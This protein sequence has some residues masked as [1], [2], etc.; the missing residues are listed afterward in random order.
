[1]PAV[2]VTTS[3]LYASLPAE[4]YTK[5][6]TRKLAPATPVVV[7]VNLPLMMTSAP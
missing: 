2:A 1:M 3:I 4:L 6:S 5:T 7:S